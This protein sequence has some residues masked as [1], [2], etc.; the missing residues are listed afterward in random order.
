VV[1]SCNLFLQTRRV[2][3]APEIGKNALELLENYGLEFA[4]FEFEIGN[5]SSAIK[6]VHKKQA[7]IDSFFQ[8]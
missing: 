1:V 7:T 5:S 2:L 6:G 4:R 3:L 8:D